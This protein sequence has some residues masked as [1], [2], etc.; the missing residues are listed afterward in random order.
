[1][2]HSITVF[3]GVALILIT[4]PGTCELAL[5]TL[6]G[7]LRPRRRPC[8][9]GRKPAIARLAIVIPAH[10]EAATIVRCV[11]SVVKCDPPGHGIA[12]SIVV[13][14]DNCIDSTAELAES[15]G[16]RVIV[17]IDT[18]RRGKGFALEDTF[19]TLLAED[20]DAV[21][22]IDADTVVESNL[23]AEIVSLLESG[24]DGVQ[25]RYGVLNYNVSIRTRLMNVA[26]MAFNVL[27]SRGR[28][29]LGMSAG[30]LGN[31]FAL[32][33][34]TLEA[35]PYD[36][37]SIVEDLEY[38][39]RLVRG[40]RKI[41]FADRATV[42]A[43]MPAGGSGAVTQRAR[44]EGGRIRMIAQH[45]TSLAAEIVRGDAQLIEPLLELLLL[46]LA[47]QVVLLLI[48]LTIPFVPARA[49][50]LAALAVVGVHVVAGIKV[51]GG[52]IDDFASL[53]AAPFYIVWKLKMS[54]SI[55]RLARHNAP[56]IRT[57]R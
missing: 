12:T 45:S 57:E 37:R 29:R 14:A 39:I 50:A 48:T 16:V 33:R 5:L 54:S 17:R 7:I 36:A 32:S 9:A 2:I 44:W 34:A 3:A 4:L 52:S 30:I 47:F 31:G 21:I 41:Q 46:P 24:A 11:R 27:R 56:W 26:L 13:I 8:V 53:L 28:D 18:L 20:F 35:V 43:E 23:L 15:M 19:A 38:H 42:R 10:D 25:A 1:M 40:G 55:L 49:Y 51:G 6:S 22:V